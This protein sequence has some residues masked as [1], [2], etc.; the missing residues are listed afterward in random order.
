MPQNDREGSSESD[1]SQKYSKAKVWK[2]TKKKLKLGNTTEQSSEEDNEV[3][4]FGNNDESRDYSNDGIEI[5]IPS[6]MAKM[7]KPDEFAFA[8]VDAQIKENDDP[9][10]L[11]LLS[12]LPHLKTIPEEIRLNVKMELMQVLRNANYS[13][14]REHKLI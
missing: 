10:R 14:T 12:L 13:L 1:G 11:F 9:D 5:S 2:S 8:N 7:S 6:K 4:S 3:D